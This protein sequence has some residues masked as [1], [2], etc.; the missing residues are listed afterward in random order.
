MKKVLEIIGLSLIL[1]AIPS[2]QSI[3]LKDIKEVYCDIDNEYKTILPYDSPP[4][5][6]TCTF[7]GLFGITDQLGNPT[8]PFGRIAGYCS[9]DFKGRFAGVTIGLNNTEPRGFIAGYTNRLFLFG[10]IGNITNEQHIFIIGIGGTN[11][12][13]FYFRMMA[14]RGPTFYIAGKYSPI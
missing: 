13:H 9:D 11:D 3:S 14:I 5:W 4:E 7:I 1:I 2:T 6:A 10:I 12:T 8:E